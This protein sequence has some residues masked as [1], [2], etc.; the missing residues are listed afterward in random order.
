MS[1]MGGIGKT[2]FAR[3]DHGHLTIW[4]HFDIQVWLTISQEYGSKNVL[5]EALHCILKQTNIDI[6]KDI[7]HKKDENEIANL[8]QNKLK[9]PRYLVVVDDIWSTNV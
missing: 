3:K 4:Y 5:L 6:T 2:T 7:Y 1:R 8:V 9:G